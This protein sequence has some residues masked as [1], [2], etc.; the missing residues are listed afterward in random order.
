MEERTPKNVP[1]PFYVAKDQCISCGA[2]E[3]EAPGL[4]AFDDEGGSCYFHRQPSSSEE[5]YRAMRALRASCCGAVRYGGADPDILS[6]LVNL[7]CAGQVDAPVDESNAVPLRTLVTFVY[8][9]YSATA[10]NIAADVVRRLVAGYADSTATSPV[11][12]RGEASTVYAWAPTTAGAAIELVVRPSTETGRW[13][14]RLADVD[15]P[16]APAI[17]THVDDA[18]RASGRAADLRWY[19]EQEWEDRAGKWSVLPI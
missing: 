8:H 5:V 7:G 9:D 13:V 10:S 2:P 15:H 19:S 6:R 4:M 12:K 16:A 11:M 17:A 18:L 3:A 14:L 1:G